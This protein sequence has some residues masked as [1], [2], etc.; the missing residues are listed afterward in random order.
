LGLA[1]CRKLV[2]LHGGELWATSRSGVGSTFTFS[3]P[4]LTTPVPSVATATLATASSAGIPVLVIDDDPA[5]IEIV[6]AY[7]DQD[8]YAV[9]GL[10]D[11]RRAL[12][13]ARQLQP[14]AI[15]LDV[16]M[17]HQ[18]GWEVLAA[19]KAEPRLQV[20]PIV[21]YT[22][23]EEQ[24]LGFYLGASAY[25]T[26]PIDADELRATLA[27]LIGS[28]ATVLVID[29]D[30]NTCETLSVQLAE[31]GGYQVV[32]AAGGQAGLERVALA[33]PD[34]IILDLM[35]PEVDGFAVLAALEQQAATRA[36]PVIVL[37]AKELSAAEH[38]DL[39][40]RVRGL[41]TKGATPPEQL[42]RKVRAL[43]RAPAL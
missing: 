33:A 3:L 25:L 17:P 35:M 9:Y 28:E 34:L 41:L 19:L 13:A 29:D 37:T 36:I 40:Q 38:A 14:A 5:A 22:I 18:D 23:V 42:L 6:A 26:K 21:L 43:I 1:I 20:V 4:V 31:S 11:S 39:Q 27:R 16:L 15:I 24:K 7:L 30:P 8:G 10:T 12:E 32:T 2:E